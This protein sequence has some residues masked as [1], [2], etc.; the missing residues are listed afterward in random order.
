MPSTFQ[1]DFSAFHGLTEKADR[2]AKG[3]FRM[4]LDAMAAEAKS[5]APVG[6]SGI[7]ANSIRAAEVTGSLLSGTLA[8]AIVASAPGA[9]AQEFGSGLQGPNAAKYPIVP[10]FKKALRF[11]VQGSVE[12]GDAGFAFRRKVM[13]PGVRAQRF[14]Q[15]GVEAKLDVLEREMKA[16]VVLAIEEP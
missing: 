5:L 2:Y 11:P 16:A 4:G 13:H 1:I 8:G 14:L 10:K 3:A 6:E 15:R 12:G 9:E 7:L